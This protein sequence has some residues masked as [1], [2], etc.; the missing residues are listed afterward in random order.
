MLKYFLIEEYRRH[1]A[2]AKEYSLIVFPLYVIFFTSISAS[3]MDEVFKI[4]PYTSFIYITLISTF[5][6]GF[7]VGSF[8]F[9]GRSMEGYT[10]VNTFSIL[11]VNAKK[12]YFYAFLRDAVYYSLLFILPMFVGLLISIPFSHLSVLQISIFSL[13]ILFSMF[14]GYSSSYLSFPLYYRSRVAYISF[15][16]LIFT[17]L[18]FAYFHILPFFV[19]DF[20]IK[21]NPVYLLISI[22]IILIFSIIA[23]YLTPGELLER[24][25]ERVEKLKKYHKR[26]KKILLAKEM[27]DIVRGGIIIKSTLTYFL[28][29]I[30]LF[31]FVRVLNS[32][33]SGRVYTPLSLTV[34][35]SI[36]STVI[37]SW[38]TIMDDFHYVSILPISPWD[39]IKTH[40]KSH[41][42]IVSL[43]SIPVIILINLSNPVF[44]IPSFLLFYLNVFYLLSITAYL[45][46]YRVTS[47]LFDPEIIMKFS[48]F[49][50]VPGIILTISSL[51]LEWL[52]YA[53]IAGTAAFMLIIGEISIKKGKKKWVYFD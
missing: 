29:M 35:L 12:M 45:A 20:Q 44:L 43:I 26:F 3:F 2:I 8:E 17:Y 5:I 21:K 41:M 10:L 33:S 39:I 25:K 13:S 16:S 32:I 9:L 40:M 47:M 31:I 11:P 28:P 15:L 42:I 50:V 38:L 6:Y 7:G 52:S 34:M 19:A 18:I 49:S 27:L 46:G 36:F 4:F 53:V 51:R 1:M 22:A 24:R 37:Y 14:L 23:Y 48:L 30:L